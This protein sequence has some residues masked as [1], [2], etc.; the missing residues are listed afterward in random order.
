MKGRK[1]MEDNKIVNRELES[2]DEIDVENEEIDNPNETK[3]EKF[4]RI[5]EGRVTKLLSWIRKLDNLSNRGN[6]E[7]TDEQVE[8]MFSA[9]EAE[10]RE[11]KSHFLRSG[12][13]EKKF[14]FK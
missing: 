8:Q 12:K 10:L 6:Y 3:N 4:I 13:E 1:S 5:A 7:Y 11:V 2:E 9:I 14:K